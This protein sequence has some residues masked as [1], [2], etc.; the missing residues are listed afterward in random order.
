MND[1]LALAFAHSCTVAALARY[2]V[3]EQKVTR[4][5]SDRVPAAADDALHRQHLA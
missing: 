2:H 1:G 5:R 4:T 3:H